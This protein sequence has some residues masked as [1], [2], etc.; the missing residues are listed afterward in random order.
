MLTLI[1]VAC[2]YAVVIVCSLI[3]GA[4]NASI[5]TGI[6]DNSVLYGTITGTKDSGYENYITVLGTLTPDGR[7]DGDKK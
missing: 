6:I 7:R 2:I 1:V 4:I 5:I 3:V